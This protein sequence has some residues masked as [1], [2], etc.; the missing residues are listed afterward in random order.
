MRAGP[1][2]PTQSQ[3]TQN[4]PPVP[5]Q[6]CCVPKTWL[7]SQIPMQPSWSSPL[8]MSHYRSTQGVEA[9]PPI[10]ALHSN[11]LSDNCRLSSP[12]YMSSQC[13]QWGKS[14]PQHSVSYPALL[15]N[16]IR[17]M[18]IHAVYLLNAECIH[19]CK[20]T[21]IAIRY[22]KLWLKHMS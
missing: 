18:A 7:R 12:F 6:L 22:L 13:Q 21:H 15:K 17:R 4:M 10:P 11:A 8:T 14:L 5:R 20:H 9:I 3:R 1:T 19:M 2:S 16:K